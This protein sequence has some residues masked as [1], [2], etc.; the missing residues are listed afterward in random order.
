MQDRIWT[1]CP[2]CAV[3]T[4]HLALARGWLRCLS[5]GCEHAGQLIRTGRM[6]HAK[7]RKH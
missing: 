5:C 4:D 3:R 6:T 1:W 2:R 7:N